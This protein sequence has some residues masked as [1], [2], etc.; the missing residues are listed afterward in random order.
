VVWLLASGGCLIGP[1]TAAADTFST[2]GEHVYTVPTGVTSV[3]ITAVGGSGASTATASGG[4]GASV[5]SPLSVTPGELL[6][7]EVG[8]NATGTTAGQNGGA[9]GGSGADCSAPAG[10]GGGASDVRTEPLIDPTSLDSRVL[11]AGGGG[12]AGSSNS[13]GSFSGDGGNRGEL[14]RPSP[15]T[16][17]STSEPT[18]GATGGEGGTGGSGGSGGGGSAAAGTTAAGGVGSTAASN[19]Y[20]CGG[21]GGGGYGGGGGGAAATNATGTGGGG[22][23]GGGGGDLVPDGSDVGLPASFD[24]TPEVTI[25]PAP[26]DASTLQVSPNLAVD[27][28]TPEGNCGTGC[29]Y[30]GIFSTALAKQAPCESGAADDLDD[31]AGWGSQEHWATSTLAEP[32]IEQS[33]VGLDDAAAGTGVELGTPFPL[34]QM[35]LW[36]ETTRGTSPTTF[37]LGGVLTVQPPGGAPVQLDVGPNDTPAVGNGDVPYY[38]FNYLDTDNTP[39][40]S[41]CDPSIQVSS[42]PCDDE[43]SFNV[44]SGENATAVSTTT[45]GGVT[46]QV[47]L[48]GWPNQRSSGGAYETDWA[49]QEGAASVAGLYAEIT[50][51]TN[52]TATSLSADA[53]TI[54][55]AVSPVAS[56][57]G[58]VSFSADGATVPGCAAVAVDTSTGIATCPLDT[59]DTS[60]H[61]VSA[62]YSGG[63]GFAASTSATET[64]TG[65]E[66]TTP[67][68]T[69]TVATTTTAAPAAPASTTS[70]PAASTT[71]S[72][73]AVSATRKLVTR[74]RILALSAKRQ[75]GLRAELKLRLAAPAQVRIRVTRRELRT[76]RGHRRVE[77]VLVGT[78][79]ETRV[80]AGAR[81][82]TVAKV[83]GRRLT[84]GTYR[85]Q[86]STSAGSRT[87]SL[88]L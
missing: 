86:V 7:A 16:I 54:S 56:T 17:D 75:P 9:S 48:L 26:A 47:T 59:L 32:Y 74:P 84:P 34:A 24:A 88:T 5:T 46:W 53:S 57:G 78:V 60:A 38:Y 64:I 51:D 36:N 31:D 79:V 50:V 6:Y 21:G 83:D 65:T 63:V 11:V 85:F 45:V 87:V 1:G 82:L 8:A 10:A 4:S 14:G 73:A 19:A 67:P 30:C 20:G 15:T 72:P 33:G 77:W 66:P 49:V 43:V 80:R 40:L 22:G 71:T 2:A 69:S 62:S 55:A 42:V 58:T 27:T 68:A 39:T 61:Q 12:G 25:T 52:P 76:V 81:T 35:V 13:G 37:A 3:E 28:N 41:G 70:T 44:G 23:G 29:T 18:G